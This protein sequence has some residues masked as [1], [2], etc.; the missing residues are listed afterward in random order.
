[1]EAAERH[2]EAAAYWADQGKR[3]RA[4]LQRELAEYERRGAEL[5]RRWAQ[6]LEN[7]HH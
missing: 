4:E 3:E 2:Q 1:M 5:E 7:D 6:L